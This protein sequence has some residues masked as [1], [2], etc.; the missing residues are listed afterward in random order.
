M[1]SDNKEKPAQK[2]VSPKIIVLAILIIVAAAFLT[3][4]AF[5]LIKNPENRRVVSFAK[6]F[7][8]PVAIVEGKKIVTFSELKQNLDSVYQFYTTQ[9]FSQLGMRVD[10]E[11]AE[12]KK[13]LKIRENQIFNHLVE[14][15]LIEML[16][17][18]RGIRISDELVNSEVERKLN[19]YGNK[20]Y[21]QEN[22]KKLYG[23]DLSDFKREVVKPS[24][25][26]S[27]LE[28]YVMEN[29]SDNKKALVKIK[30]AEDL[31]KKGDKFEEVAK[32]Y[33]EGKSAQSG[34]VIDWVYKN[35]LVPEVALKINQM[36]VG[37][38][39]TAVKSGLGYHIIKL[40]ESK[41]EGE[42]EMVKISQIFVRIKSFGQW[43]GE[44][45]ANAS[46]RVML[47]DY[48]W[49]K[50]NGEIQFRLEELRKFEE[51]QEEKIQ[52]DLSN[53]LQP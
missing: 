17:K 26:Q 34:G 33:S 32:K 31:L 14:N 48:Q 27:E 21:V 51:T 5:V 50:S 49:D 25:Y 47:R 11:T 38:M 45:K 16:A 3:F 18:K 1:E 29:E 37:E 12:G 52:E 53:F 8:Y 9:D 39:S 43:L 44:Q 42:E 30:E 35:Q 23:W 6:F 4:G 22:L 13:R 46:V 40:E 20:D 24:L 36:K 28:K 2:K 15:D 7:P 19:E 41:K 10:F